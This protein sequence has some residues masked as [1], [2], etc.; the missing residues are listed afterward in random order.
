MKM[1]I[2]E[3]M[4][5]MTLREKIGQTAIPAP[6]AV[7]N[8]VK[9][10]GG[11]AEFFKKYP[12]G[13]FYVSSAGMVRN[14][15]EPL[16]ESHELAEI[17]ELTSR[18]LKIPL[19]VAAD[20]EYG[21]GQLFAEMARIPSNMLV[22][23][24]HS[25]ILSYK[26]S[27]YWAKELRTAGINWVFG[28]VCDVLPDFLGALGTRTLSDDP[29]LIAELIP[30][31]F[32]GIKNAGMMSTAKHYPGGIGDYR[33][34][35]FSMCNNDITME[36]WN[37][38]LRPVWEAAAGAGADSFMVGHDAV[39]AM[40]DTYSRGRTLR[41]AS[42]S[43]KVINILRESIGF[44]GV[45]VTDAVSMKSLAAAFDHEDMY[46]ECFNAGNDVILFCGND[47]IDVMEKAVE[48]GRV[49]MARIDEAVERIL[50]AKKA[51]GLF[52]GKILGEA[53]T[54]SDMEDFEKTR[55]EINKQGATLL[56]NGDGRIPFDSSKV[57]KAAIIVIAPSENF[58]N[59]L[60]FLQEAFARYGVETQIVDAIKS[61]TVLKEISE[62]CD[63]IMYAC[64]I[65]W[66]D[67]HGL[68]GFSQVREINTLFNSLSYGADKSVVVSF[69]SHTIYYNYFEGADA[70]I[71][72][73]GMDKESMDA[74]V[75]GLFGKF[76]FT[77]KSPVA[78]KP[79]RMK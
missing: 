23:A 43:S 8:E 78:L 70:F 15:G 54:K 34:P 2:E 67:P 7:R 72:M 19:F 37:R 46:I 53:M 75:D 33:D 12:Y 79:K 28:P 40:D 76:E 60:I 56:K 49:S 3:I 77:G 1:K 29:G 71:N 47:Y 18:E 50:K 38:V 61:K 16:E 42:A 6:P 69:G 14:G 36:E 63:L 51:L 17:V 74:C 66:T 25:A 57:K 31:M 73:Y 41:P 44:D 11:Y 21:G 24:A 20:A 62:S 65:S 22:G 35:H 58:R 32:R 64:Y 30:H 27:Y 10:S 13:G 9:N 26:R 39:P 68:P 45:V 48:E 55:Y 5:K 4:E 59:N 52:D